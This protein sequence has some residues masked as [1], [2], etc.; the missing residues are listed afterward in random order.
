MIARVA[1][2]S[3]GSPLIPIQAK[4][5]PKKPGGDAQACA[6]RRTRRA[7]TAIAPVRTSVAPV[8][9]SLNILCGPRTQSFQPECRQAMPWERLRYFTRSKPAASIS[10]GEPRLVGK[11]PDRLDEILVAFAVAGHDLADPRDDIVGVEVIGA[12]KG[13]VRKL[14]EL[15][16]H[17]PAAGAKHP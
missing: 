15:E 10:R 14:A 5:A 4:G 8:R 6:G 1:G 16:H 3:D 17:E 11:L 12:L 13:R 2:G 9:I 7:R